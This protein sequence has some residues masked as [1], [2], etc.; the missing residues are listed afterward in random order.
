IRTPMNG[1][2]GMTDILLD[3]PLN[4]EQQDLAR[5]IRTSGE[6]LL[7]L[8]NDILDLS[9]IEAGKIQ[10]ESSRFELR[11]AVEEIVELLAEA[12]RT[13]GVVVVIDVAGDVPG[14]V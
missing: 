9:K 12:P 4:P 11:T 5:T 1:V 7:A 13:K 3:T 10:I 8:L 14:Q 6:A 2:I